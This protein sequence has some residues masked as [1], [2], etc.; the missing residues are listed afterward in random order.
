M[1]MAITFLFL[2]VS[3]S[4]Y[5]IV[6]DHNHRAICRNNHL[7]LNTSTEGLQMDFEVFFIFLTFQYRI[8]LYH[9][10]PCLIVY[11]HMKCQKLVTTQNSFQFQ[12]P[13][14]HISTNVNTKPAF[15][16]KQ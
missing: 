9:W 6:G 16:A 2:L 15:G 8:A 14:F 12:Y 7:E 11:S 4:L 10:K 5:S 13:Q 3:L 1:L